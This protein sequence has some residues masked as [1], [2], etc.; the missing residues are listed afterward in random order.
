MAEVANPQI[1]IGLLKQL[2]VQVCRYDSDKASLINVLV[3]QIY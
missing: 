2:A 1:G 3:V